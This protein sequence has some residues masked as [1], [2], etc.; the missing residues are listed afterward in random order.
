[1]KMLSHSFFLDEFLCDFK[2]IEVASE[3]QQQKSEGKREFSAN[4]YIF[5]EILFMHWLF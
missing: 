4:S 3:I 2:S 1:M 5:P